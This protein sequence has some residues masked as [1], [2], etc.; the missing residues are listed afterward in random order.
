MTL[1]QRRPLRGLVADLA[2]APVVGSVLLRFSVNAGEFRPPPPE[3]D[4]AGYPRR[5]GTPAGQWDQ[6][7]GRTRAGAR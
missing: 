4:L 6:G 1:L 3:V 7:H 2:Q 5:T